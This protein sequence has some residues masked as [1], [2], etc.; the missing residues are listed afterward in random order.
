MSNWRSVM[1]GDFQYQIST[2]RQN[3]ADGYFYQRVREITRGG[4]LRD[5]M[6]FRSY[7]PNSTNGMADPEGGFDLAFGMA[8]FVSRLLDGGFL[9]C[10]GKG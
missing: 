4:V 1:F 9:A 7:Q 2:P 8:V 10:D 6:I 5:E 3:P